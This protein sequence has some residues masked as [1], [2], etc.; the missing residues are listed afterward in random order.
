M[1]RGIHSGQCWTLPTASQGNR[2]M[3]LR[4][5][6]RHAS[7][8]F[9]AIHAPAHDQLFA[10]QRRGFRGSITPGGQYQTVQQC[11]DGVEVV[12]GTSRPRSRRR[13]E[14]EQREPEEEKTVLVPNHCRGGQSQCGSVGLGRNTLRVSDTGHQWGKVA[15]VYDGRC[16]DEACECIGQTCEPAYGGYV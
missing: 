4:H 14:Q 6:P 13:N 10:L 2:Q 9:V 12:R 3:V 5:L 8:L 15:G 11:I 16:H 1:R 7:T